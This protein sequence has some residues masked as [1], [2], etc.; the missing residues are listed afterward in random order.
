LSEKKYF[1]L[2]LKDDFFNSKEIKKLRRI[3]GG[4]TY[5]IIFLKL[6]LLSIKKDGMI[7]FDGTEKD[8]IEQLHYQ[9]DE[10]EDNIK[11]TIAFLLSNNLIEIKGNND[12]SV[13]SVLHS[14]GSESSVTERVRKHREKKEIG[15]KV[16]QCNNMKQKCNTEIDIEIDIDIEKEKDINKKSILTD[17][18]K[19]DFFDVESDFFLDENFSKTWIAFVEMRK[20]IKKPLTQLAVQRVINKLES[21]D[22]KTAEKMIEISIINCWADVYEL[23]QK[24]E[25][26]IEIPKTSIEKG[27]ELFESY[28]DDL[29]FHWNNS[30]KEEKN[31][32]VEYIK[33]LDYNNPDRVELRGITEKK[34]NGKLADMISSIGNIENPNKFK[35]LSECKKLYALKLAKE[36]KDKDS[37][38]KIVE[39]MDYWTADKLNKWLI[40]NK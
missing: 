23:K 30:T 12:I 29:Y 9:L 22:I 32:I 4:D 33:T 26:K 17:T 34:A 14:I 1:W 10:Q 13:I 36:I 35:I 28:K 21:Y 38:L 15:T 19:K 5:V 18:K 37:I 7:E 16:L 20:K 39:Q 8:I 27:K 24:I 25:P 3:A 31:I 11:V 6:Q 40:D 2:K